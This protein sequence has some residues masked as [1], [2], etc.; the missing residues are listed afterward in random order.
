MVNDRPMS[1]WERVKYFPTAVKLTWKDWLLYNNIHDASRTRLNSWTIDHPRNRSKPVRDILTYHNECRPGRI[2]RR[3][4]EQ[5]RRFVEDAWKVGPLILAYLPPIIGYI[6]MLLAIVAPRQ[7]L[8]RRFHNSYE[9]RTYSEIQFQQRR[10][11]FAGVAEKFIS[12]TAMGRKLTVDDVTIVG[13]DSAGPIFDAYPFSTVFQYRAGTSSL[14]KLRRGFLSDIDSIPLEYLREFALAVGVNQTLPHWMSVQVTAFLPAFV[15]RGWV[16]R[17]AIAVAED[18]FLL[19]S[20]DA[21]DFGCVS[22]TDQE[23]ID[24]SLM[25]GLPIN[26]PIDEMRHCLT[27]HLMM[28]AKAKERAVNRP[29]DGVSEGFGLFSLHLPILRAYFRG[30]Q[31][32]RKQKQQIED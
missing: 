3:Q 11:E 24:A 28:V 25:R 10:S 13:E 1:T 31:E 32:T 26:I 4:H 6:P 20:E 30:Q 22:L 14:Y 7:V 17:I 29:L 12:S 2:P 5:Q 18:D 23:V 27:N 21:D 9:I 8:S 19:L 16:R 15:I